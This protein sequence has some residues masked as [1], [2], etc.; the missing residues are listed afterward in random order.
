MFNLTEAAGARLAD[1]LAKKSAG[2]D[3]VL[4]FTHQEKS[5]RW[6]LRLDKPL[7]SDTA[8]SHEGRIVLV[9]DEKSSHL[10]RNK[11][12][13]IRETDGGPRLRLRC[14]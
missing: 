6:T 4:R 2:D 14:G 3:D 8:L 12:L 5:R 11:M 7:A 10:L 13:D 1:K 9:L